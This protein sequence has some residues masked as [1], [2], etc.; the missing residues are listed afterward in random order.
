MFTITRRS[1]ILFGAVLFGGTVVLASMNPRYVFTG[2][3]GLKLI[4]ARSLLENGFRSEE[5]FYPA[6]SI[7]P[8][9][10][11]APY[12]HP[13]MLTLGDRHIGQY[14]VFFAAVTAPFLWLAGPMLLPFLSLFAFALLVLYLHAVWKTGP[15]ALFSIGLGSALCLHAIQYSEVV[16]FAALMG[17]GLGE[18]LRSPPERIER[19][20]V[21]GLLVGLSAWF[22]LESILFGATLGVGYL[23]VTKPWRAMRLE[24]RAI[25]F[26]VG[27]L[28]AV[29]VFFLFN[30]WDYG[31]FLG[32]RHLAN[33]SD[34]LPL[35][36][37]AANART[38]IFA[39]NFK[40]GFLAY[41]PLFLGALVVGFVPRVHAR[42]TE[43]G[44]MLH[45]AIA[46]FLPIVGFLSP[47]DGVA[48]WGARFLMGAVVPCGLLLDD[49]LRNME[50]W[51]Q[52][53]RRRLVLVLAVFSFL[54]T[55]VGFGILRNATRQL[56]I[57]ERDIAKIRA[58][59]LL[60]Q[61]YLL[62]G[63]LG[64][65]YFSRTA[66]LARKTDELDKMGQ[67]LRAARPGATVAFLETKPPTAKSAGK[68]A[69]L[70]APQWREMVQGLLADEEQRKA[71]HRK[72]GTVLLYRR[73]E[74]LPHFQ[75]HF[76]EIPR[77]G[78]AAVQSRR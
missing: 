78:R 56:R 61:D 8:G 35:G 34:P 6:R 52:G 37:R 77:A 29:G 21:G 14:P 39:G 43:T 53:W 51:R 15:V 74:T 18:F 9:F 70:V 62:M 69:E 75:A 25:G 3:S 60:F 72:L 44:R 68:M 28:A 49:L 7:D 46:L 10:A 13:M 33:F 50:P 71:Y 38:M 2:D 22:R 12:S 19:A 36:V 58:D 32:T 67:Q 47:N 54:P 4:Q 23:V 16:P 5:L 76:Y 30:T 11:F 40:I 24:A 57:V 20:L 26:A 55:L 48:D 1:W 65:T 73:S 63:H 41:T 42:M 17:V 27:V 59:V 45:I 66:L 31:H 64:V